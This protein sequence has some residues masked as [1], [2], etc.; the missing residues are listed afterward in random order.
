M[1]YMLTLSS[2]L[3]FGLM[4]LTG[5][6]ADDHD[7]HGEECETDADCADGEHCHVEGDEGHCEAEEEGA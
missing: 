1:K 4:G 2:A 3:L 6:P 5:C 7:D